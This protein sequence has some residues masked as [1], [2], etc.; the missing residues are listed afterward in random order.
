MGLRRHGEKRLNERLR[1][2]DLGATIAL[3]FSG[4]AELRN[5]SNPV[6]GG[7]GAFVELG[8]TSPPPASTCSSGYL[9]R[10]PCIATLVRLTP[11]EVRGGD[12]ASSFGYWMKA[13]PLLLS[14][15]N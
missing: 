14:R 9:E 5:R 10:P 1:S 3:I 11:G 12:T 13:C 6:R 2:I 7:S 8:Q 15:K 4:A